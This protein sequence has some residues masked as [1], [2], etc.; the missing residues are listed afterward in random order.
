MP[1]CLLL[2]KDRRFVEVG[3]EFRR[4]LGQFPSQ[5]RIKSEFRPDCS[6]LFPGLVNQQRWR[7]LNFTVKLAPDCPDRPHESFS[8]TYR[9]VFLLTSISVQQISCFS[10]WTTV[11]RP[12]SSPQWP[13]CRCWG[14]LSVS[15]NVTSAPGW[16]SSAPSHRANAP[17][18]KEV[19]RRASWVKCSMPLFL[20]LSLQYQEL[21]LK[22]NEWLTHIH[23]HT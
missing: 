8:L 22:W 4:F 14:L 3:V 5:S 16:T 7:F 18:S 19:K 6:G 15:S 2:L 13:L 12:A 9:T 21:L 11:K 23:I 17:I 10:Y 20:S 1:Y